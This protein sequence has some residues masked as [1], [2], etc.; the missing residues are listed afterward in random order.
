MITDAKPQAN[1]LADVVE[2][3]TR[4]SEGQ[5][6]ARVSRFESE[7]RYQMWESGGMEYAAALEV[8]ALRG[9]RV[10]LSPFLPSRFGQSAKASG[11]HP[12][13]GGGGTRNLYQAPRPDDNRVF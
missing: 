6:L 3:Q 4:L 8:V 10:R 2:W 11:F 7:Y 12:E 5:V 13:D 1:R 9:L